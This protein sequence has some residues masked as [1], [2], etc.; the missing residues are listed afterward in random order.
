MAHGGNNEIT[1]ISNPNMSK[2]SQPNNAVPN[3]KK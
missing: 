3:M 1:M 2:I